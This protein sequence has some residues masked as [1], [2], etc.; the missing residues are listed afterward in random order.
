MLTTQWP[1]DG[2]IMVF[3]SPPIEAQY[4]FSRFVMSVSA[5]ISSSSNSSHGGT[6]SIGIGFYTRN[7]STLSLATSGLG[8]YAWTNTSNNST[9]SLSGIR[10]VT[11]SFANMNLTPGDYWIAFWSKTSTVNA[12]WFTMSNV[13]LATGQS[14]SAH[15]GDFAT[16]SAAA[17]FQPGIYGHGT[18]SATSNVLPVSM[19]F[20]RASVRPREMLTPRHSAAPPSSRRTSTI[21]VASPTAVLN[22]AWDTSTPRDPPEPWGTTSNV[23]RRSDLRFIGDS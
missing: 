14:Q 23:Q 7:S 9:G 18:Y 20:S 11:G 6:L 8:T 21:A 17:S 5:S 13:V 10:Q 16:A 22:T 12:N 4:S 1:G 15:S 2:S 19:A 3:P